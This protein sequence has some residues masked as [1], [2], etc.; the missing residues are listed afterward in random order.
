MERG[1][2]DSPRPS[3]AERPRT[4]QPR[5]SRTVALRMSTLAALVIGAFLLGLIPM[6][7]AAYQRG[8]EREQARQELASLERE[9]ALATAALLARQGE[10][11]RAR[12]AASRFFTDLNEHVTTAQVRGNAPPN[13][14]ALHASLSDRDEIITLLARS[15]PASADRLADLYMTYTAALPPPATR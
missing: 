5:A 14:D 7:W 4:T 6:G 10:Y 1:H 9:N 12:E 3:T 11:E 8:A 15:D 13:A 2:T